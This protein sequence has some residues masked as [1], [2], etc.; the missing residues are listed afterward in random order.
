MC[1]EHLF[2]DFCSVFTGLLV[3]VCM[4]SNEGDVGGGGR[5]FCLWAG[6]CILQSRMMWRDLA[7]KVKC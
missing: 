7:L 6:V 5:F 3:N 4:C 1:Y 2:C